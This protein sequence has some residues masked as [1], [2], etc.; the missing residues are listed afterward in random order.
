MNENLNINEVGLEIVKWPITKVR[1]GKVDDRW[2]V[3]YRRKPKWV[4]DR[5]WW[6][7]DG[8]YIDYREAVARAQSMASVGYI[9]SI[10][11][12]RPV[13]DVTP[14][15]PDPVVEPDPVAVQPQVRRVIK[16]VV[17]KPAP[18]AS[19]FETWKATQGQDLDGDGDID[20]NDFKLYNAGDRW[21]LATSGWENPQ[22]LNGDGVIDEEDYKLY[23]AAK[24]WE[25]QGWDNPED[26]DGDGDIDED[27]Y[28]LYEAAKRW[29]D[30]GWEN[31]E[32]LDG[33][34][35]IDEDDYKLYESAK[36]WEE[37]G[38]DNP[39]DLNNDGIIDIEDYKL[40]VQGD[41]WD[42]DTN[43]DH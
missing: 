15:D 39:E 23:E 14:Y 4:L 38:W 34:G 10:K 29:E 7:D 25:Q 40:Y 19:A 2:L 22:D 35:D 30:K 37:L 33:D 21:D 27:D 3:E 36:R 41:R 43:K 42:N 13:F 18:A 24:R 12:A 6:F 32:D 17:K 11:N 26:L 8:K 31:P 20:E 1:V 9:T 16:K 5:W 28:K